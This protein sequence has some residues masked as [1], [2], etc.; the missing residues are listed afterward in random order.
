MINKTTNKL[1]FHSF[2]D[3]KVLGKVSGGMIINCLVQSWSLNAQLEQ[4]CMLVAKR[5]HF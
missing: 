2:S 3:G 5:A 4:L 1:G